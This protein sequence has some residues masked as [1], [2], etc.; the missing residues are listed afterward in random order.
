[1]ISQQHRSTAMDTRKKIA[2]V[3]HD[4]KKCDL[5]ERARFNPELLVA[6]ELYAT[7]FRQGNAAR[8]ISLRKQPNRSLRR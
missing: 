3:A 6:P 4:N 2:L 8:T 1:M 7:G 5:L